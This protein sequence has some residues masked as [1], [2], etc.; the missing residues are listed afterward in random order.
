MSR[1]CF[2]Y[3]INISKVRS[4]IYLYFCSVIQNFVY[5]YST[6]INKMSGYGKRPGA[7]GAHRFACN[8]L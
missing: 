4:Q 2:I 6:M 1:K 7:P 3:K 5:F 8:L